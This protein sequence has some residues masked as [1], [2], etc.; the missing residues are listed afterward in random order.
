LPVLAVVAACAE[1]ETRFVNAARLRLKESDRLQASAELI[2]S[3]GGKALESP[4]G[5]LVQ[6]SGR[7]QDN[8]RCQQ[9]NSAAKL[10]GGA[11]DSFR[12]HRIAMAAA[13][14]ALACTE[15]VTI[16][17]AEAVAK[18]YPAFYNDYQQLGGVVDVI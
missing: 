2:R 9:Q 4:D 5:L 16:L 14:A 10:R 1:G 3:L 18:S 13:V 15:P 17:D 7:A 11:V 12:D 6:G 8:V